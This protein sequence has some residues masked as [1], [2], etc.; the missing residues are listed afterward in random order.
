MTPQEKLE[1][2]RENINQVDKNLVELFLQRMQ[3]TGQIA[4]IKSDGNIALSHGKREKEMIDS[5]LQ[6]FSLSKIEKGEV[7]TFLRNLIAISKVYQRTKLVGD[8]NLF[9]P[10]SSTDCSFAKTDFTKKKIGFQGIPG[11]WSEIGAIQICPNAAERVPLELF[12]DVFDA[13]SSQQ[14]DFGIVPIENSQTGAIGEVYDLLRRQ[15]CFIV[16]EVWVDVAHC[17]LGVPG[18]KESDVREV[19]SHPEGFRQCSHFLKK[20]HWDFA[21]ARNTAVSAQLVAERGEKRCAAIASRR[22]AEIYGL[23]VIVPNIIDN[24]KNRTRF[25][26]IAAAP[27]Y[28]KSCQTVSIT[29]ST[30][31]LSGALCT[32]LQFFMLAGI[33]LSRIESRPVSADKYRFFADLQGNI[34]DEIVRDTC[35]QVSAQC[36]YLEILGCY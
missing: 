6:A 8:A 35:E 27:M 25:I 2:L 28:D 19:Y 16:G 5:T 22:A 14:V 23:D 7:I 20:K 21:P 17:L 36:E 3:I 30:Q 4:E 10:A 34:L 15:S 33:N 13:V 1:L 12:E 18:A 29:F 9:F 11:A 24:P 26:A 31:H 32:V